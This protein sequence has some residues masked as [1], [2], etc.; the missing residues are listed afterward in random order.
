MH[1]HTSAHIHTH[2]YIYTI[3]YINVHT[4]TLPGD[5]ALRISPTVNLSTLLLFLYY[6]NTA[7]VWFL[8]I[9]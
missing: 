8:L 1:V 7:F 5:V 9:V 6:S 4:Y 2:I 3:A